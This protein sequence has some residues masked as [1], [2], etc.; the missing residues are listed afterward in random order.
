[1]TE[2]YFPD[3]IGQ[4]TVKKA[5]GFYIDGYQ[6]TGCIPHL[7]FTAPRGCG[8]TTMATAM[9]KNLKS[10]GS[11]KPLIT[12]NCST[13]KS[14]KQFFNMIVIPHMVDTDATVLFD[15]FLNCRRTLR[16]HC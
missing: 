11:I 8:K 4:E 9:A 6:K 2:T 7:M 14:L 10:N 12:L 13:I 5:L 1:M 3:I 15:E 16:W